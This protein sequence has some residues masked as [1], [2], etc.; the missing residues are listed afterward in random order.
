MSELSQTSRN[1]LEENE[2][3]DKIFKEHKIRMEEKRKQELD[4][5]KQRLE[6]ADN[7][8]YRLFFTK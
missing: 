1:W 2:E 7:A 8:K 3:I 6:R 4:K 5:Y